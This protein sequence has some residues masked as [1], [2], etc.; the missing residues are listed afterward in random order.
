MI[1]IDLLTPS[2][3]IRCKVGEVLCNM[4]QFSLDHG[5]IFSPVENCLPMVGDQYVALG[6]TRKDLSF[7]HIGVINARALAL[8]SAE[9]AIQNCTVDRMKRAR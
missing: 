8:L 5:D 6:W 4:D 2:L 7:G 3:A 1:S 9:A